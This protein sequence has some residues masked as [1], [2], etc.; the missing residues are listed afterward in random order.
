MAKQGQSIVRKGLAEGVA[1]YLLCPQELQNLG[2]G[3]A[4]QG[5]AA[6]VAYLMTL[7]MEWQ[8]LSGYSEAEYR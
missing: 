5:S 4:R 6:G 2:Q 8:N 1:K 3:I 7:P